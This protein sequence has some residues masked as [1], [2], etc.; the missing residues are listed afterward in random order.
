MKQIR[1]KIWNYFVD[2]NSGENNRVSIKRNMAWGL[3]TLTVF[4]QI[5]SVMELPKVT[6]T[7]ITKFIAFCEFYCTLDISFVVLALGITSVEKLTELS[8]KIRGGFFGYAPQPQP[9]PA[10]PPEQAPP[11]PAAAQVIINTSAPEQPQN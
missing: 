2:M 5:Y 3:A 11:T 1:T 9:A 4:I 6:D 8:T 7:Q 10:A